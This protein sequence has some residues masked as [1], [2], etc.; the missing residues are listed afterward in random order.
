MNPDCTAARF[1]IRL[2]FFAAV[3]SGALPAVSFD[4]DGLR[5]TVDPPY[6]GGL[7]QDDLLLDS[8]KPSKTTSHDLAP[9]S[10]T[11][12][13]RRMLVGDLPVELCDV[14][15]FKVESASGFD[16]LPEPENPSIEHCFRIAN[17][18]VSR[19]RAVTAAGFIRPLDPYRS[20]WELSYLDADGEEYAKDPTGRRLRARASSVRQANFVT[21]EN[22]V[23]QR[24]F[25]LP[26]GFSPRPWDTVLLDAYGLLPDVG[27]A[28]VLA[29]AAIEMRIDDALVSLGRTASVSA[30]FWN[31]VLSRDDNF[32]KQPS[33]VERLD[34]LLAEV[35]GRSLKDDPTLWQL[36][37]R[38]RKARNSYAHAGVEVDAGEVVDLL[39]GARRAMDFIEAQLPEVE[40]RPEHVTL[41]ATME[42]AFPFS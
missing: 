28:V 35:G 1:R 24:T 29:Y 11:P 19:L 42:I 38:L 14:L 15:Q 5:V 40:R 26:S 6:R 31:W 34:V 37:Q 13:P 36:F 21:L 17:G 12:W 39:D 20:L 16:R 41:D 33:I 3:R 9:R 2:P 7:S 23:W 10:A 30:T 4:D 8:P 27:A 22:A 18:I 25:E 32:T